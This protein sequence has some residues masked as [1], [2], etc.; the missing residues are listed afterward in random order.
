M[1]TERIMRLK[2][3]DVRH[4]TVFHQGQGDRTFTSY[5]DK[6]E[7]AIPGL[8]SVWGVVNVAKP[9]ITREEFNQL[10]E[11]AIDHNPTTILVWMRR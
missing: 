3:D 7:D 4:V 6:G 1:A 11:R 10:Y 2:K 8:K 9:A 5:A